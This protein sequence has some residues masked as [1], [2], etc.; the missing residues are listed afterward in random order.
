MR[1]TWAVRTVRVR[2]PQKLGVLGQLVWAL[3][4]SAAVLRH[5]RRARLVHVHGAYIFN[6]IPAALALLLGRRVVVMPLLAGGDL[7]LD[8]RSAGIPGSGRLRRYVL[9]NAFVGLSL[10]DGIAHEF[11]A[12]GMPRRNIIRFDNLV[13][14]AKFAPPSGPDG[15]HS[16]QVVGFI[17]QL[18]E[19]KGAC[20][21]LA[22]LALLRKR[23]LHATALF[24]GPFE[25]ESFADRFWN[26]AEK[27]DVTA[28]VHVTGHLPDVSAIVSN[29]ITVFALPSRAEG[30]PGAL[31]ECLAAGVP[32]VVSDVGAM[33]EVIR[34]SQGGAVVEP[35]DPI[36]LADALSRFLVDSTLWAEHS[37]RVSDYGRSRFGSEACARRYTTLCLDQ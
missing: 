13:D 3:G 21:V 20:T 10:S 15:R 32:A 1:A 4:A 37:Q 23:G 11:E 16:R 19:R 26:L 17:G 6:L 27:L 9:G 30:M 22:A 36:G 14:L 24:V 35:D 31:C 29:Q 33:G 34:E 2:G 8:A 28:F 25:D 12:W 18:G 7:R 5:S